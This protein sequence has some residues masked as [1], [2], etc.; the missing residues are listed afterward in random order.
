VNRPVGEPVH[1]HPV[2]PPPPPPP[3]A[4]KAEPPKIEPP[5]TIDTSKKIA[6]V[7][8]S[9]QDLY[10][11]VLQDINPAAP[12]F[13]KAL[14]DLN[15]WASRFPHS[16]SVNDRLY[17]YIHVYNGMSQADKV[18]DTAAPLVQAGVRN[19][20]G[21]QQQVLQILVAA[22][23]S[24][25]KLPK[26]TL[27]QLETGQRAARELLEFL[28]GYFAPRRKPSNVSEGDWSLARVQLEGVA[29]DALARHSAVRVAA[30]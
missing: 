17:Y 3:S 11:Q 22:S 16:P 23:A 4:P 29:R 24:V 26:P 14:N 20:F 10:R 30:N 18:L 21:D 15:A 19:G 13:T 1:Q 5:K 25:Q 9:E 7:V 27:Q 8:S 28:P 2:T 12:N 6:S